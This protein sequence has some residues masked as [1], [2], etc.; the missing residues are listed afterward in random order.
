MDGTLEMPGQ[1]EQP[2]RRP[3]GDPV[4]SLHRSSPP[5]SQDSTRFTLRLLGGP[6]YEHGLRELADLLDG[7]FA[8]QSEF[9]EHN[10][11]VNEVLAALYAWV[12]GYHAHKRERRVVYDAQ[13]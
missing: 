5:S 1:R 12:R 3:L 9:N 10:L 7:G 2:V 6:S 11:R 13:A 8:S 4:P